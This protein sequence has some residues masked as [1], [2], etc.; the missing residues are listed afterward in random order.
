MSLLRYSLYL[1]LL[2]AALC[3]NGPRAEAQAAAPLSLEAFLREAREHNPKLASLRAKAEAAQTRAAG[4]RAWDDPQFAFEFY[5]TPVTSYNPIADGLENDYSLQQMIHFPGKKGLMGEMEEFGARMVGEDGAAYERALVAEVKSGWAMLLSAQQRIGINREM[6]GLLAQIVE[7]A[8]VRL[9]VGQAGQSAVLRLGVEQERLK[10]DE[11]GLA[12]ERRSAE[13]MLNALRGAPTRIPIVP[14]EETRAVFMLEDLDALI[15]RAEESRAELRGMTAEREM[16]R[17]EERLRRRERWPDFMVR[18]MYKQ[19]VNMTDSWALMVGVNIP[20]A[21]WSSAK[22]SARI[23]EADANARAAEASLRDMRAMIGAQ[24][25]D[26][27]ERVSTLREQRARYR[28]AMLPQSEAAL[29]AA[30]SEYR[31]GRTDFTSLLEGFRMHAMLRMEEAMLAADE[32]AALA[33]LE[34]AVGADLSASK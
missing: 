30:Q 16:F 33:A 2:L 14:Q 26:A 13:A 32:A 17:T 21:P 7:S 18:G 3:T 4:A 24:V 11:A 23:E 19:M 15:A 8:R 10:N 9:A 20:I 12:R 22:Y 29:Q 27:W 25:R 6:Q 31:T 34:R 28:D 5:D 1:P